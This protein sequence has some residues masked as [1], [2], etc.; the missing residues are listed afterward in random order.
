MI[1]IGLLVLLSSVGCALLRVPSH[2]HQRAEL[3]LSCAQTCYPERCDASYDI[4]AQKEIECNQD[5]ERFAL[6]IC[7]P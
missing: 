6:C 1:R 4:A 5:A 3:G 7:R 2:T